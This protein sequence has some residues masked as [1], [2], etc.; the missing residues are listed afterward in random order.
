[1]I[2]N[3][4]NNLKKKKKGFTL[5]ELIIVVAILGI[6]AAVAIPKFTNVKGDAT[7]AAQDT[8]KK[9]VRD[10]AALLL[11]QDKVTFP[12]NSDEAEIKQLVTDALNGDFPSN[13]TSVKIKKDG[14]VTITP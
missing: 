10:T 5:I 8:N 13:I 14:T 7:K 4:R 3:L 2:K 11:A 9:V 12:A 1:M 6:L